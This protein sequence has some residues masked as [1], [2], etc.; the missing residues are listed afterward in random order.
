MGGLL[1][2]DFLLLKTQKNFLAIILVV[3]VAIGYNSD[4]SFAVGYLTFLSSFLLLN[5]FGYDDNG[6]CISF[7]LTLPVSRSGYV[8]EKYVFGMILITCGFAIGELADVG[9]QLVRGIAFQPA[10]KVSDLLWLCGFWTFIAAL[11][12]VLFKYG[13]ERGRICIFLVVLAVVG[14]AYFGEKLLENIGVDAQALFGELFLMR[15]PLF[16]L[17]CAMAATL[18]VLAVS[19]GI[20]VHIMNQKEY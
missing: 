3:T 4:G 16:L 20:S 12:P 6:S 14:A 10:E 8:R 5:T 7:L 13:V 17:A 9:M 1:K 19:Y 11:I 15:S 18:A 2:K